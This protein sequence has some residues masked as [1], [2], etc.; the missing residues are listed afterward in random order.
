MRKKT[1]MLTLLL[2]MGVGIFYI[3]GTRAAEL[4]SQIEKGVYIPQELVH[5]GNLSELPIPRSQ[6]NYAFIQAI[7]RVTNIVIGTFSQGQDQITLISDQDADGKVDI[8][9]HWFVAN[10]NTQV[11]KNPEKQYPPEK[12]ALLKQEILN[13][14]RKTM[15]PN[16]E[17]VPYVKRMLDSGLSIVEV[18]KANAGYKILIRD[19]DDKRKIQMGF[20]YSNNGNRGVDLAFQ[21]NYYNVRNEQV[22]PNIQYSVYCKNSFDKDVVKIV[23]ELSA[24]TAKLFTGKK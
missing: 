14:E 5:K 16:K 11:I 7:G 3:H 15:F 8:L 17:G 21:V 12:F 24:Y 13:G 20:Y 23:N 10:N 22:K 2:V 6:E 9:V 1:A 19:V 4:R 18:V